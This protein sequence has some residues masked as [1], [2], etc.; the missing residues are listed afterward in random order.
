MKTHDNAAGMERRKIIFSGT[1]TCMVQPLFETMRTRADQEYLLV[2]TI[3]VQQPFV[4]RI[5]IQY[6]LGQLRRS[7][8][9][10]KPKQ[11]MAAPAQTEWT[12]ALIKPDAVRKGKAEV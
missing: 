8:L 10:G 2:S 6:A 7:T 3:H 9:R 5:R 4:L 1:A 12:F 11:I